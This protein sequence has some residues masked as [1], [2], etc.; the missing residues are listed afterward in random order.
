MDQ[1]TVAEAELL[2]ENE[3]TVLEFNAA[4]EYC[5]GRK[6]R[7]KGDLDLVLNS[8]NTSKHSE[9]ARRNTIRTNDRWSKIWSGICMKVIFSWPTHTG[10]LSLAGGIAIPDK[11]INL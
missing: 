3:Q 5:A 7:R 9:G 10:N 4:L 8:N 2:K 6:R 1:Q 11:I